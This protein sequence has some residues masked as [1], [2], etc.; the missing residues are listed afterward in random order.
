[1]PATELSAIANIAFSAAAIKTVEDFEG[2]CRSD[3]RKFLPHGTLLCAAGQLQAGL[4]ALDAL[5]PVDYPP[6]YLARIKRQAP[7]K[8]RCVIEAWLRTR[9]PQIVVSATAEQQL[10][11]LEL[12]EFKSFELVNIA[13]HGVIE[14]DARRATYFSF[15]RMPEP[16][17][18][19]IEVRLT[20]L[21]PYLHQV[22]CDLRALQMSPP[23]SRGENGAPQLTKADYKV[24][25]G[26]MLGMK[27]AEIAEE[28]HRSPHTIKCQVAALMRKLQTANRA[29]TVA[30]AMAMGIAVLPSSD[31][32][33]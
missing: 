24:L 27:N 26:L 8:D 28:V 10:S 19:D 1:M 12:K 9:R 33:K 5:H 22:F 21:A 30:K 4:I 16:L 23:A 29:E 32:R 3:I 13:A 25:R 7:L 11:S 20:L 15:S 18:P 31:P 6:E 14:P 17:P 2:W